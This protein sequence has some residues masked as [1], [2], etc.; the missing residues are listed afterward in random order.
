LLY[1]RQWGGIQWVFYSL[2]LASQRNIVIFSTFVAVVVSSSMDTYNMETFA[3]YSGHCYLVCDGKSFEVL[4][5]VGK[6]L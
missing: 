2:D 5:E 6:S 1:D 4:W 3:K